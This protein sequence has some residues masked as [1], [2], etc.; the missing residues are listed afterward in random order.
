MRTISSDVLHLPPTLQLKNYADSSIPLYLYFFG[1]YILEIVVS[2]DASPVE[3]VG[4][5]LL[6]DNRQKSITIFDNNG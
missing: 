6:L 3:L 2:L 4:L 1:Q 5:Q